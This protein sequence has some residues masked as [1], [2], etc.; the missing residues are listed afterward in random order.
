[1]SLEDKDI[2][3]SYFEDVKEKIAK[4][5]QIAE[6]YENIATE[7]GSETYR[8]KAQSVDACCKF[9]DTDYY[10][11]Q[12]VKDIKRVNLCKDK[13]CY[14]CQSMLAIRRQMKFSPQLEKERQNYLVAHVIVTVPNVKGDDLAKVIDSMYK[15]FPYMLRYLKG[16]KKVKGVNFL[17]YGY[18]GG[19]RS[20]EVTYNKATK[21]FHPHFHCMLLFRPD[22]DLK[23]TKTN[24]FSYDKG[25]SGVQRKFAEVEILLQKVWYLLFN[26]ITVTLKAIEDL[27]AGYDIQV[28]DSQGYFHE[29]FKYACKGA[30]EDNSIYNE[31][32]FRVLEK[33][34]K[35]RRIIQGYGR[36]HNFNDLDGEILEAD[37]QE[38]YEQIIAELKAIENPIFYCE[39]LEQVIESTRTCKYI[40]KSNLKK[41]LIERV[42]QDN[43]KY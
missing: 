36:L 27:K 31:Q 32:V 33:A 28:L 41:L 37:L 22:L 15:K 12:S 30:F 43:E 7:K 11:L 6:F 20:L 21:E 39:S 34:L 25:V 23:R 10:R 38:A 35:N 9:W 29:C 24:K 14:N 42:R 4:N 13:F 1:M 18:E 2:K 17:K 40:S 5:Y 26:G 16:Q 8:L 19:I 3:T